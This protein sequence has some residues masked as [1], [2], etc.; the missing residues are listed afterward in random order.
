M[1]PS[2]EVQPKKYLVVIRGSTLRSLIKQKRSKKNKNEKFTSIP[3]LLACVTVFL[4][5]GLSNHNR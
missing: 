4:A 3:E 2:Q 1:V 5:A